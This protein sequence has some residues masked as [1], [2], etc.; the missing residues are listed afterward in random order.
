M[1]PMFGSNLK[2]V[3]RTA[4]SAPLL[5]DVDCECCC[6]LAASFTAEQAGIYPDY[7]IQFMDTSTTS[8]AGGKVSWSWDF[9]DGGTSTLQ[10]P[11][12]SYSLSDPAPWTVTLTV[13][14]ACGCVDSVEMDVFITVDCPNELIDWMSDHLVAGSV[15]INGVPNNGS[16]DNCAPLSG[17]ALS[18]AIP[19]LSSTSE[20]ALATCVGGLDGT[21]VRIG[22]FSL[23]CSNPEA[24]GFV[25]ANITIEIKR[26][27]FWL[28][29]LS[30][31]GTVDSW[32]KSPWYLT[33]P[34][35]VSCVG[36]GQ[37]LCGSTTATMTLTFA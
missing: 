11:S 9:G 25:Q 30:F 34:Y 36:G 24:G 17:L 6:D 2:P 18:G 37:C 13:T 23:N 27:S 21:H 31:Q 28:T 29:A 15:T 7:Y 14:D 8:C 32:P 1:P 10:N 16:C 26:G 19:V 12:H 35:S 5:G 20:Q 33:G 4:S 3:F 22:A